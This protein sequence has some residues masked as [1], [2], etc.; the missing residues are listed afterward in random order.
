MINRRNLL[1]RFGL[2]AAAAAILPKMVEAEQPVYVGIDYGYDDHTII[3]VSGPP[4][5]WDDFARRYHAGLVTPYS[6]TAGKA[7]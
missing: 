2:G 7:L 4:S 6:W 1:S 3:V 5:E